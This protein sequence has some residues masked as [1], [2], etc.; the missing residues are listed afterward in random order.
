[1]INKNENMINPV[2]NDISYLWLNAITIRK[3]YFI[4]FFNFKKNRF[5]HVFSENQNH[6]VF[7]PFIKAKKNVKSTHSV[8][9]SQICKYFLNMLIFLLYVSLLNCLIHG[10]TSHR[11]TIICW[12]IIACTDSNSQQTR[13]RF[14]PGTHA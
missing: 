2:V 12:R 6:H 4:S 5:L 3:N 13:V 9:N 11:I 1:M 7:G 10:I 8:L 14:E